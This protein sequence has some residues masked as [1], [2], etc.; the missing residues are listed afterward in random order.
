[1]ATDNRKP[2]YPN[3]RTNKQDEKV[4]DLPNQPQNEKDADQ[5]KGGG[6]KRLE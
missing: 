6:K 5:V 4:G 1:M 2:D 3:T